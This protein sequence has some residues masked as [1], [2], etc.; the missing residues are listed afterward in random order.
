MRNL[1]TIVITLLLSAIAFKTSAQ[2][3]HSVFSHDSVVWNMLYEGDQQGDSSHTQIILH[4]NTVSYKGKQY[5]TVEFLGILEVPGIGYVREENKKVYYRM[6][7]GR[8][9]AEHLVYDFNI[10]AN[11]TFYLDSFKVDS[12]YYL[13]SHRLLCQRV[14]SV[15]LNGEFTKTYFLT[16]IDSHPNSRLCLEWSE[17]LM[18]SRCIPFAYAFSDPF[19]NYTPTCIWAGDTLLYANGFCFNSVRPENNPVPF[20]L[21]P[22]PC[23]SILTFNNLN[24]PI[25][26]C[27]IINSQGIIQSTCTFTPLSNSADVSQL[28][29]GLYFIRLIYKGQPYVLK[30]E[31]I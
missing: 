29:A 20:Y 27:Q 19:F 22:N 26:I 9:T 11:D 23:H 3:Y 17:E 7:F 8:D 30:F 6:P 24:D 5:R 1:R 31:K 12:A 18:S 4:K 28:K 13:E 25:T 10:K 14:D 15:G 21:S 2:D 16:E